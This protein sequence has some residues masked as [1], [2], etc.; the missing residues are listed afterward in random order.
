MLTNFLAG[1]L[2]LKAH[3][4]EPPVVAH[5]YM[6]TVPKILKADLSGPEQSAIEALGW[7]E[8]PVYGSY[9]YPCDT[10]TEAANVTGEGA[11]DVPPIPPPIIP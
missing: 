11:G 9:Y 4:D 10:I 3:D 7:L 1:L 2:I 6:A 8:H 5:A